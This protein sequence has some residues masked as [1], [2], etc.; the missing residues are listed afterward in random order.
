[1]RGSSKDC[2]MIKGRC[3][4]AEFKGKVEGQ[5]LWVITKRKLKGLL[6]INSKCVVLRL[7]AVVR[8]SGR[9]CNYG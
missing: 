7:K 4:V 9:Y 3:A 8:C 6:A 1:M 5:C 2:A